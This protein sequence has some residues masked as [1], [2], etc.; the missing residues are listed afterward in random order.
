MKNHFYLYLVLSLC[1]ST[2]LSGQ[3]YS[4]PFDAG[5]NGWGTLGFEFDDN[6]AAETF[7]GWNN[8]SRIRSASLGGSLTFTGTGTNARATSPAITVPGSFS[9]ELYLSFYMYFGSNGGSPRVV[10]SGDNGFTLDTTLQI[11]VLADEE[12]SAGSYHL[13]SLGATL[14]GPGEVTVQFALEGSADF[15]ILDDVQ[16]YSSRPAP[17]TFP[18]YVGETLTQ[19]GK[20]FVVDSAGAPAV[21]FQL[22]VDWLPNRTE[23]QKQTFRDY[24]DPIV[25]HSCACDRLEVW[26]MPGGTF[27]DPVTGEPLGDPLDILGVTLPASGMNEVDGLDLNYYL[28]NDLELIPDGPNPPLANDEVNS[29]APAPANAVRIAILDTGL[30]LDH[31]DMNGFIFR[32]GDSLN[33]TDDDNDCL[34]DNPLGWNYVDH[35]NNPDDDNGHGTHVTGIIARNA[36]RCNGCVIQLL[37]YKTHDSYGV[38]TLFAAAC[39]ILQAGVY[40][41]ADIIN[42]S[43]GFYAGGDDGILRTAIDTVANYGALVVAAAGNDSLN[44]V[45]DPQFPALYSLDN[46]L[47][48]GAHDTLASGERPYAEFSNYHDTGVEIAAFGVEVTSSL[49]EGTTG[50]KSGTSMATPSVAAAAGMYHCEYPWQIAAARAFILENAFEEPGLSGLFLDGNALN[51]TVFCKGDQPVV[52]RPA[53][54]VGISIAAGG[55]VIEVFSLQGL[56]V[57]EISI[58]DATGNLIEQR[59]LNQF[60]AGTKETFDLRSAADGQYLVVVR[61]AGKVYTQRLVKR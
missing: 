47:A 1:L 43:W 12:T 11:G 22:V 42:C 10:V 59:N 56:T 17:V 33:G 52:G 39:G 4:E 54:D 37:P 45:A 5:L 31:P 26:E 48:V 24:Y 36:E 40:D 49:L 28:Y 29:F 60:P 25:L 18:R 15:W 38:G 8:R 53:T 21:P 14:Q 61:A 41:D 55:E 58:T 2:S 27:F 34:V 7:S 19:L 9:N 51:L 44:L 23:A 3:F 16:L 50:S 57:T 32:D 30:D 13:L 6:G 20:P 35:N 46:I